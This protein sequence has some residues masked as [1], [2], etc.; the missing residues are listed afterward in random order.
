MEFSLIQNT[1]RVTWKS[2]E[3]APELQD[4]TPLLYL[5]SLGQ[6]QT[7]NLTQ[8]PLF[9]TVR[10]DGGGHNA[11]TDSESDQSATGSSATRKQ[12]SQ[13]LLSVKY[14]AVKSMQRMKRTED[15]PASFGFGLKLCVVL[16]KTDSLPSAVGPNITLDP[17]F[18]FYSLTF[19]SLFSHYF[20]LESS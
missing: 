12:Q 19:L 16:I 3:A 14:S 17:F 4:G 5:K 1:V 2:L 7:E 10:L 11:Q 6:S 15:G 20:Q 8:T 13:G 18:N 9:S